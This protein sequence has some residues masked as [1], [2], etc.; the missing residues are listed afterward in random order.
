MTPSSLKT[1]YAAKL[2]TNLVGLAVNMVIQVIIPRGLGPKAYGDFN[3]LSNFFSELMSFFSLNTSIGFYTR[4]SQ[5]Q[6]EFGLVSFYFKFTGLS[7]LVLFIFVIGSQLTGISH[8][9]WLDQ[10]IRYVYMAAAWSALTWL[11]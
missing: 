1:R 4:L 11:A 9:L 5:R 2:S 6:N 8:I 3:F 7:I 10:N